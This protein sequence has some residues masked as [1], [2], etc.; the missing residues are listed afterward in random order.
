M[1]KWLNPI[2]QSGKWRVPLSSSR[3]KMSDRNLTFIKRHVQVEKKQ[4][5]ISVD[6]VDFTDCLLHSMC[7]GQ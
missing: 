5:T 4:S 6:S 3:N 2:H 1:L 7:W